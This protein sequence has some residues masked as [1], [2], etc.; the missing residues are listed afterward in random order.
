MEVMIIL[1]PTEVIR[2]WW[3]RKIGV[4]ITVQV[5][6][7]NETELGVQDGRDYI[8][9]SHGIEPPDLTRIC[10][11]FEARLSIS[12]SLDCKNGGLVTTSHNEV[13][14]GSAGL[15]RKAFKILHV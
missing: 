8:F 12:Q 11:R 7:V 2:L 1:P 4:W 6:T 3:R 15:F 10:D 13:Q 5:S 9:L 14:Y